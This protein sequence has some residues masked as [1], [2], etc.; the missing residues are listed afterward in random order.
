MKA[1]RILRHT[2][3]S[4]SGI[5]LLG[6]ILGTLTRGRPHW[7]R[8][9]GILIFHN[10]HLR[11][12]LAAAITLGDTVLVLSP[13][14]RWATV[15]DIPPQLLAHEARH[16]SQFALLLG[17]PYLP[18]YW[19]ACVYSWVITG[20]HWSRNPFEVRAGLPDGGYVPNMSRRTQ[21]RALDS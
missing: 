1:S 15:A 3:N 18:I 11:W 17:F 5:T 4:A 20:D 6:L 13:P 9:H 12:P 8:E 16:A 7:H 14:V 10:C 19:L 2:I 21:N